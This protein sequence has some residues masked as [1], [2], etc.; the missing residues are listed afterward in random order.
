MS[1]FCWL[2]RMLD[3]RENPHY[4]NEMV[5]VYEVPEGY[6]I[7]CNKHRPY[8][9]ARESNNIHSINKDLKLNYKINWLEKERM[10]HAHC[11]LEKK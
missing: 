7:V 5:S 4:K 2:C 10:S 11:L 1:R 3:G 6:L 8:F 9:T